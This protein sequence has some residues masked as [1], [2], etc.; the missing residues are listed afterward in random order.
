MF[1]FLFFSIVVYRAG[2]TTKLGRLK[3]RGL[4]I[5]NFLKIYKFKPY[6]KYR[7]EKK[8]KIKLSLHLLILFL[9]YRIFIYR[10]NILVPL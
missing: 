10:P 7:H 2:F 9:K 3:P 4:K 1:Y 6:L 5:C 8:T